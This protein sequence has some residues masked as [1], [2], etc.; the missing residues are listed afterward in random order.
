MDGCCSL[1]HSSWPVQPAF[2]TNQDHLPKGSTTHSEPG[3]HTSIIYQE[4]SHSLA[5][6]LVWGGGAPSIE[7]PSSHMTVAHVYWEE[8]RNKDN[9]KGN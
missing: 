4:C 7:G 3:T 2:Y 1:A 5:H 9:K 8:Q 6:R